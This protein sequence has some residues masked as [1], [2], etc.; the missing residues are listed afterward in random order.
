MAGKSEKGAGNG[1]GKAAKTRSTRAT[2]TRKTTSTRRKVNVIDHEAIALRAYEIF[3]AGKGGTD[4]D[5]WLQAE[6]EL[7]V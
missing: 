7:R 3:E 5:H 1:A 6:H 4:V 2:T